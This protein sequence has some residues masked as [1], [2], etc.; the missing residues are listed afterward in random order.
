MIRYL[1][2]GGGCGF[3]QK[4]IIICMDEQASR[5]QICTKHPQQK[6]ER[7]MD[8]KLPEDERIRVQHE[9]EAKK[10]EEQQRKDEDEKKNQQQ[11]GL[12]AAK[13]ANP[14]ASLEEPVK[15]VNTASDSTT[16]EVKKTTLGEHVKRRL[17]MDLK[18]I[19]T[20]R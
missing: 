12:P 7:C 17:S 16:H 13:E 19:D 8:A 2:M 15:R 14:A 18:I 11:K 1:V 20:L 6:Y 5:F 10:L 3:V 4:P 9:R